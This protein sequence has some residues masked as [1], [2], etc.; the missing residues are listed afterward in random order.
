MYRPGDGVYY[1]LDL[2]T[3]QWGGHP[4]GVTNLNCTAEPLRCVVPSDYDGDGRA[5]PAVYN[6]ANATWTIRHSATGQTTS[7]VW[8]STGD[9]PVQN[10]YDG[11]GRTDLAVFNNAYSAVWTIR[12][13]S[14]A[15]TRTETFGTTGD[16]PVPAFYR[17]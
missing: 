15:T 3:G 4:L 9:R 7:T 6:A 13:S 11:D 10:D 5:D 1:I 14:D 12:R 2:V 17:R 8:G 16:I